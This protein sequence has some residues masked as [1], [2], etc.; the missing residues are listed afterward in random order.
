MKNTCCCH[1]A[2]FQGLATGLLAPGNS[3]SAVLRLTEMLEMCRTCKSEECPGIGELLIQATVLTAVDQCDEN[4]LKPGLLD[5]LL[6]G[7]QLAEEG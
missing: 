3:E 4:A 2:T 6:P 7:P 5:G 1:Q